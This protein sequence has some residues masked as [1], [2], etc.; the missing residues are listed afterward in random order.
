MITGSKYSKHKPAEVADRLRAALAAGNF[1]IVDETPEEIRFEHGT[2]MTSTAWMLPKKGR[3]EFIED[4]DG[5]MVGYE[6]EVSGFARYWVG[7][8]GIAFCWLIFPYILTQRALKF[9]PRRLMEN[10]LQSV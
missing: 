4:N 1:R 10:L 5:T 2:Y 8:I 7:G 6:V 9:H 3:L